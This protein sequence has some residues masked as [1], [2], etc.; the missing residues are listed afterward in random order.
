MNQNTTLSP[1]TQDELQAVKRTRNR[2][3]VAETLACQ[4]NEAYRAYTGLTSDVLSLG[5]N[6]ENSRIRLGTLL[7]TAKTTV[8][9]GKF[10]QWASE[11]CTGI[12]HRSITTYMG[13]ARAAK[14]T[15][16]TSLDGLKDYHKLL[17]RCGLKEPADGHGPQRLHDYNPFAL[18]TK[19]VGMT[20]VVINSIFERRPIGEWEAEEREQLKAQLEPLNTIY[21]QL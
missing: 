14:Y 16:I 8:G 12:S 4:I 5:L 20:R 11:N 17:I 6:I 7:H 1:V 3:E 19:Q 21:Y 2:L 9:H 15:E 13:L 18:F 10:L